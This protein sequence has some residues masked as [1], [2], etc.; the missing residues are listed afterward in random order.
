MPG[1]FLR[2]VFTL[3]PHDPYVGGGAPCEGVDPWTVRPGVA[4]EQTDR[5]LGMAD[6]AATDV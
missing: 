2:R 3:A 5:A 4:G 1:V 6:Q